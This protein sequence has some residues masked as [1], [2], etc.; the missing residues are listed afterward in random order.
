MLEVTYPWLML[1]LPLPILVRWLLPVY[2]QS[3][4]SIQVPFFQ[5][6]V[7]LSG[8]TPHKGTVLLQ[9]SFFQKCCLVVAWLL[10][11]IGL[12]KPVWLGESVEQIKSARDLMI[13]VDLSG[14]MQTPDFTTGGGAQVS[15]LQAVKTVLN[16]FVKQREHDRLGLIVFG[17]AAY[18]QAPFTQDHAA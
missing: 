14:S 13:A 16:E 4:D 2:K 1:C 10:I 6:L 18:L 5:R 9:R 11:V 7:D 12:T 8:E 3:R 17:D 15:R